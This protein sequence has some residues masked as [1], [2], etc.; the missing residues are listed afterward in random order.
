M[1][2][3]AE[4]VM[5]VE[6]FVEGDGLGEALDG[7]GDAFLEAAAPE[8]GLLGLGGGDGGGLGLGG[9]AVDDVELRHR[10]VRGGSEGEVGPGVVE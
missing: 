2:L 4:D 7:V 9:G 1:G 5:L 8:L 10:P 3:G 6:G